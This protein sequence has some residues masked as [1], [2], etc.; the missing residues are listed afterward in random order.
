MTATELTEQLTAI[1]K[2]DVKL[3]VMLW[4]APGL[5]KSSVVSQVAK[6]NGLS[7][8]DLRLSQL[9]PGDLRGLPVPVDGKST[10]Y[11][12]E[13]LPES[14]KGVLL[15]DEI[16]MSPPAVQ[17]IAQQLILDRKVGNY[18]VPEGWFIWAAGNRKEDKAAVFDM[19]APLA[20][21]FLHFEISADLESFRSWALQQ[22][23]DEKILAFLSFRPELLHAVDGKSPAWPSP[24]SWAMANALASAKLPMDAAV[25]NAAAEEFNAFVSVYN[26]LPDLDK[27]L[28][29]KSKPS[30]P[31][32]P[33]TRFAAT[34]GLSV[35]AKDSASIRAA[36]E[37]LLDKGGAEWCQLFVSSVKDIAVANNRIGELAVL[38]QEDA[39]MRKFF[40]GFR[41]QLQW[42]E[43]A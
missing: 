33:S 18:C 5:G 9:T 23:V 43:A 38:I 7:L 30:F 22:G 4:G 19:P 2:N 8:I 21:R 41:E 31:K 29:G 14:G 15:L 20:N 24:R 39:R 35:R 25:G 27:I 3:S 17:A 1:V 26:K 11:P 37:W 6:S 12:P 16:N 10:W 28:A 34:V 42:R 13:F 40:K 32:E 36:F